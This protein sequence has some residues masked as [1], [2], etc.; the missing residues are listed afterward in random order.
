MPTHHHAARCDIRDCND[1]KRTMIASGRRSCRP[2]CSVASE[3]GSEVGTRRR[4]GFFCGLVRCRWYAFRISWV[5]PSNSTSRRWH[6]REVNRG[7]IASVTGLLIPMIFPVSTPLWMVALDCLR[8]DLR[9]GGLRRYGHERLQP[10]LLAAPSPSSLIRLLCR[11]RRM[12][13]E[14]D[15]DGA[16]RSTA[17]QARRSSSS[18]RPER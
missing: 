11:A 7:E 2:S 16:R 5:W 1:M 14:L 10:A 6:G 12:V 8:G 18:A 15:D 4:S 13:L 3:P 9:Q 17:S